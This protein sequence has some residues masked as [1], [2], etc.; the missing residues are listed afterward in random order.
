MLKQTILTLAVAT[1]LAQA[2]WVP[3]KILWQE[4]FKK[5]ALPYAKGP[6]FWSSWNK[7]KA[8]IQVAK[9][10][11]PWVRNVYTKLYIN[12]RLLCKRLIQRNFEKSPSKYTDT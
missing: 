6:T 1:T 8:L 11:F 7:G 2:V 9:K 3:G 5:Y 12:G 4:D 10:Y